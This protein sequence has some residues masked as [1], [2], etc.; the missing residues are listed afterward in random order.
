MAND[1]CHSRK[2]LVVSLNTIK[3]RRRGVHDSVYVKI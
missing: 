3:E 2:F 1:S